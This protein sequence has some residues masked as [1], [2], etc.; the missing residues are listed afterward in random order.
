MLYGGVSESLRNCLN[1][2][3]EIESVYL[4]GHFRVE[5][6]DARWEATPHD[7][8]CYDGGFRLAPQRDA[9]D[10]ENIV[11][12]GYPFFAGAIEAETTYAY[13]PGGAAELVVHGRYAVCD[14]RVNGRAVGRLMFRR[15]MDIRRFLREGEITSSLTLYNA[16]RN[17]LGP[18]HY[19]EP[20][21]LSVGPTTFSLESRWQDEQCP[22]FRSRYAF[23]RFGIDT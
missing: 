14:V 4:V 23:V 6:D 16:N 20:E 9:I 22:A 12:D 1:F 7:A 19:T 11:K 3:T 18:H 17:L 13:R 10:L 8:C 2:D 15:H 5:T 21:P